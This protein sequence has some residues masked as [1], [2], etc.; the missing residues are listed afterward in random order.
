MFIKLTK[1]EE[2]EDALHSNNI[3]TGYVTIRQ[4]LSEFFREPAVGERFYIGD[5]S[6]SNVQE[7]LSP[8]TFKTYNS[9]Y[10]W[11]EV[12]GYNS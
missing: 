11:E 3:P 6:T 2:L 7:I 8:N 10:K 9:I 12:E 4:T 5:F 1:L